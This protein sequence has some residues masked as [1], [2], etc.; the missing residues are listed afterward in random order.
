[1]Q[2]FISFMNTL[3]GFYKNK[4]N[5]YGFEFSFWDIFIF[6]MVSSIVVRLIRGIFFE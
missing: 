5:I 6:V 1:M 3:I 4:M 2:V